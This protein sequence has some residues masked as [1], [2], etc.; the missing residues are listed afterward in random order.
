MTA[1]GTRHH[2]KL[3]SP[4]PTG[5]EFLNAALKGNEPF[6]DP[7]T[8]GRYYWHWHWFDHQQLLDE[9]AQAV[10]TYLWGGVYQYGAVARAT[11]AGTFHVPPARVEEIYAPETFGHGASEVL[12]VEPNQ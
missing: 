1:P 5:L 7:N 12:V 6:D 9:R 11:T 3:V 10:T 2:V 4:L 8:R